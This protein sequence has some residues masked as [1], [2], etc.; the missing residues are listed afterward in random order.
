MGRRNKAY[1]KDLHQQAYDRL[2]GM[3]AF[4][5]SKKEAT[6]YGE[7][8]YKIYSFN[9]YKS[10]WKHTKYFIKYIKENHPECTTLKSAKKYVN[11]R[12]QVRVDKG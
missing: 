7:E 9:T 11:E 8:K 5:E 6:A 3:Q 4:G 12:L 2:T 10:Y 1:S